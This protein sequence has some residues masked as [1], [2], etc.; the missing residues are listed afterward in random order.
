MGSGQVMITGNS[1]NGLVQWLI[2]S[3]WA[4]LVFTMWCWV[5]HPRPPPNTRASP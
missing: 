5:R 3:D 2:L 1:Q 4:E